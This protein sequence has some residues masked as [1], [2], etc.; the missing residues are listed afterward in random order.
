MAEKGRNS[1]VIT[2]RKARFEYQILDT[3]SAGIVLQGTEVKSLRAGKA[4]LQEAFCYIRKDEAF[5]KNMDIAEYD[6]GSY[7][8][9]DPKRD[10]KLLLRKRE[11]RKIRKSLEE[12]GQTLIPLK[13][14]FNERNL[15]KL[16]LAIAKG[17]KIHDK[18]DS[19]KE[20][21][22]KREMDR[23]MKSY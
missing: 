4:S 17:K 20:K 11:I 10:R 6:K 12:K 1:N 15:V 7:N 14:Y 22:T 9:H 23:A 5:I 21:D 8:N 19:I 13:M 3:Y 18:R 16:D 2:N